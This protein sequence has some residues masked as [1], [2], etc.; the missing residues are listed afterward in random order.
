[1]GLEAMAAAAQR[2][3][4]DDDASHKESGASTS[5]SSFQPCIL[6]KWQDHYRKGY[7]G[8]AERDGVPERA[9]SLWMRRVKNL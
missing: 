7:V 5:L 1:M 4:D 6:G 3:N 9:D 2:R 8:K